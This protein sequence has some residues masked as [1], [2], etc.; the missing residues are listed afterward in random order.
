MRLSTEFAGPSFNFEILKVNF[1]CYPQLIT[2]K[3]NSYY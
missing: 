3:T 1:P 2:L